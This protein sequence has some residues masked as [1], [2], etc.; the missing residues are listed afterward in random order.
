MAKR[1]PYVAR[2]AT[3]AEYSVEFPL[4]ED[5]Q[6][7]MRVGQMVTAILGALTRDIDLDGETANGDVLQAMA[8]ALAIRAAMISA[9]KPTTDR[10]ALALLDQ[11]LRAMDEADI[12][13]PQSGR[14]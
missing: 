7:P 13:E 6:S 1:L 4:H 9:P 8:M 5:T 12:H 10:I 2:T 3:G 11:A 14:A